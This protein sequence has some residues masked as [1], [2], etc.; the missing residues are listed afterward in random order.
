M[1]C[2]NHAW[3]NVDSTLADC[4]SDSASMCKYLSNPRETTKT[5]CGTP[6]Y[7]APEIIRRVHYSY[8]V[9]YWALGVLVYEMLVG[10]PPFDGLDEH[11]LFDSILNQKVHFPRS[12][13]RDAT[14]FCKALLEKDICDRLG[15]NSVGDR[16][17]VRHHPFFRLLNW[18]SVAKKEIQ[19]CFKPVVKN[20]M[21]TR[22]FD[23]A[24]ISEKMRLTPTDKMLVSNIDQGLFED[25]DYASEF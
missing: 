2:K 17:K 23:R 11:E 25:F 5:F 22:N 8:S 21:D 13:S 15:G 1:V 16:Q 20:V 19:P 6:D 14:S 3:F 18:E 9:D 12:I 4:P 24:F 10:M 7:I